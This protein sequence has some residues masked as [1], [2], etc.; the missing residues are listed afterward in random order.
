MLHFR[1]NDQINTHTMQNNKTKHT[2]AIHRMLCVIK[3][4]QCQQPTSCVKRF[5]LQ[6]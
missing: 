1:I 4:G 5:L 2:F 6:A 3:C